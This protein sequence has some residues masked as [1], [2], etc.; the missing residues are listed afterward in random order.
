[1]A[2]CPECHAFMAYKVGGGW[3][4]NSCGWDTDNIQI[5]YSDRT[6]PY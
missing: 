6:I 3:H 5:T 4:C 1:M 2:I